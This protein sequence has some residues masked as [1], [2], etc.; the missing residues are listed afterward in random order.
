[1][2][3]GP[4]DN[5]KVVVE[6]KGCTLGQC[7]DVTA[8]AGKSFSAR[9]ISRSGRPGLVLLTILPTDSRFAVFRFNVA[10]RF[11]QGH[12]GGSGGSAIVPHRRSRARLIRNDLV[13]PRRAATRWQAPYAKP[14]FSSPSLYLVASASHEPPASSDALNMHRGMVPCLTESARKTSTVAGGQKC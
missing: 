9:K 11:S 2:T 4:V 3:F 8:E 1:M 13:E 5:S 7:P 10:D 6:P 14:R 12:V